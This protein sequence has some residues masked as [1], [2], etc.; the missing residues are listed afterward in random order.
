MK[1]KIFNINRNACQTKLEELFK[2]RDK[3]KS[4]AEKKDYVHTKMLRKKLYFQAI[5]SEEVEFL[6]DTSDNYDAEIEDVSII[7]EKQ[8]ENAINPP[9]FT[10]RNDRVI[11]LKK[12]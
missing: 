7:D 6:S 12:C 1:S 8:I 11:L 4:V 9:A 5:S 3:K 10:Y 2:D